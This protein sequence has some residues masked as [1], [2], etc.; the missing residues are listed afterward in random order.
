VLVA[1]TATLW[2]PTACDV[3]RDS[4]LAM[5]FTARFY[6]GSNE[7]MALSVKVQPLAPSARGVGKAVQQQARNGAESEDWCEMSVV[8][9][10]GRSLCDVASWKLAVILLFS[11]L[12][13]RF[14][15]IEGAQIRLIIIRICAKRRWFGVQIAIAVVLVALTATL[16][17][18]TACDVNRDSELAMRFTARFYIGSNEP[19]A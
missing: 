7:V 17:Q 5:R 14:V 18:P 16:W 13:G 4:E 9:K 10:L 1:L 12:R 8:R 19:M 3:N 11:G 15:M 2:Q 6:I